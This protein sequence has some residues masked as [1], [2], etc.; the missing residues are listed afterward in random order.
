MLTLT[1]SCFLHLHILKD[2]YRDEG[3]ATRDNLG[4]DDD[5]ELLNCVINELH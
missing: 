4:Y 1:A 2:D 3:E 5:E